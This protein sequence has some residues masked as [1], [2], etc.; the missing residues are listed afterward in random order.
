MT[1]AGRDASL[2]EVAAPPIRRGTTLA[3]TL[4]CVPDMIGVGVNVFRFG[5]MGSQTVEQMF[6]YVDELS[7]AFAPYRDNRT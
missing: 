1:E 6:D 5:M 4:A 7:S 3:E 2:L